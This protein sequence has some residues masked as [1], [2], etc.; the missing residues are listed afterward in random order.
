MMKLINQFEDARDKFLFGEEEID[1]AV[2][3]AMLQNM[4]NCPEHDAYQAYSAL[5]TFERYYKSIGVS[6]LY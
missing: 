4:A 2:G 5:M 3:E 1:R 6:I